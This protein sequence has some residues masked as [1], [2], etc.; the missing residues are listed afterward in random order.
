MQG[1]ESPDRGLLDTWAVC[2]ELVP[3]GSV[4]GF[5]AEHR[6]RLFPDELFE[7]LFASGRG[8]PSVP[9]SVV[10]T[11]MVLQ[12][13]EGCSD[14]EAV[15]RLECDLR[16]KAAA[17]L[18]LLERAFH[19]T[20]LALWRARL[21]A[22]GRGGL[23]FD[24]VRAL[25]DECG[26]LD[27]RSRRALDST[28]LED[29]VATQDTVTMICAQVRRVRR[30]VPEAAAA[31]VSAR[32]YDAGPAKPE[33]DWADAGARGDLVDALVDDALATLDAVAGLGLEGD[34]ADAVG[35]LGVV[36]GQDVEEDPAAPGR[37]R[38][39]R[40][41]AP[42]R[43]ISTVDPQARC[44]RKSRSAR[45]D[46]YKAH[47][48]AEP[49][50]G[51]VCAAEL[52]AADV[53][54]AEVGPRLLAAEPAPAERVVP[55]GAPR[56]RRRRNRRALRRRAAGGAR[57]LGLRVG[58]GAGG[59]RRRR[60]GDHRQAHRTRP[61]DPRRPQP[62]RLRRRRLRRGGHLPRRAHRRVATRRGGTARRPLRRPLRR[63]PPALPL[64]RR[65]RW[66]HHRSRR[67]RE[68]PPSEQG[69][70]GGP[71]RARLLPTARPTVERSIA[72]LTR[73][74]SR[75]VPYRGAAANHQWLTVRAA[76][77][78]LARL[79]NLGIEHRHGAFTLHAAH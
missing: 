63:L 34:A 23:V 77:V 9:G 56:A 12:A 40:A 30:L 8:R 29:A 16:W 21:R 41:V 59:L 43:V 44:A 25:V 4:Y 78:N 18:G 48:S 62:R 15:A 71:G 51:L 20:V 2:G 68:P 73:G 17:G 57:G 14:R 13:L 54:D 28:L 38:I 7:G 70:L 1:S 61:A 37:W 64:H 79:T 36:A 42:D 66:A 19:P 65:P 22:G 46:G 49:D 39:A 11:V 74:K 47:I 27:G 52:T 69:P 32:D 60:L 76:A 35:L 45:R 50:T 24:A 53:A 33:C 75:R 58:P 5:L 6:L 67:L 72:W 10:A 26:A 55:A 31:A 3:E